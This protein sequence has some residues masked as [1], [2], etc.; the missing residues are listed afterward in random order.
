M[1]QK[2][3]E[4][5]GSWIFYLLHVDKDLIKH[6]VIRGAFHDD[7]SDCSGNI[8]LLDKS[9]DIIAEIRM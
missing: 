8:N 9:H 6:G 7:Y 5:A 3:K 2:S 4:Q 1:L